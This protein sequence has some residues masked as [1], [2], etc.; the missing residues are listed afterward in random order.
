MPLSLAADEMQ[1]C[2]LLIDHTALRL[3]AYEPG[4]TDQREI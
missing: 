4:S 1:S 3:S 2:M